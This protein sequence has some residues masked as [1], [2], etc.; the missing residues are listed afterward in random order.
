M[1]AIETYTLKA[2]AE[3]GILCR[4]LGGGCNERRVNGPCRV[5]LQILGGKVTGLEAPANDG[6]V[7]GQLPDLLQF[8]RVDFQHAAISLLDTKWLHIIQSSACSIHQQ[9]ELGRVLNGD[10]VA[11]PPPQ[12]EAMQPRT[13]FMTLPHRN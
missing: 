5:E 6:A 3:I 12:Q 8:H 1:I 13:P 7:P 4:R 10:S 9:G 11:E 2:G